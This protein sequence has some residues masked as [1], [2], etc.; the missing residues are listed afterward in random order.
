MVLEHLF[1]P[2][3]DDSDGGPL[4]DTRGGWEGVHDEGCLLR[5]LFCMLMWDV[6]FSP[7]PDVFLSPYQDSPLDLWFGT[8]YS[9]RKTLIEETLEELVKASSADLISR[10]GRIY[11]T[12]YKSKCTRMTWALSL[13][14]L[15]LAAVC[16]GGK[17]LAGVCRALCVNFR[18]FG[19]GGPDLLLLRAVK[20]FDK[21]V[22]PISA[23]LGE[24]WRHSFARQSDVLADDDNMHMPR[25]R[26]KSNK[27]QVTPSD[28]VEAEDGIDTEERAKETRSE[29]DAFECLYKSDV[30]LPAEGTVE[31]RCMLVEVKGPTDRL[32]HQQITWLNML[33]S[34]GISAL[35]CR[36]RETPLY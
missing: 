10:I 22:V 19:S 26:T 15:Q 5:S 9:T 2:C 25:K 1:L 7:H 21:S 29:S 4:M 8:F 11:R 18:Y 32:S 33:S 30:L 24:N 20:L 13:H 23:F 6:L 12:N 36:I 17:G 27:K 28:V 16:I 31:F 34:Q 3:D 35:V 14:L